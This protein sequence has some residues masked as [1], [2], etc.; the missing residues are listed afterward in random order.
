MA[1]LGEIRKKT[2]LIFVVIGIAMLAFVAGDLFGENSKIK[3]LFT[4]D[5]NQI[6]SINGESIGINE[7]YSAQ[8]SVQNMLQQQGQNVSGNQL[9]Q[10]TWSSLV[11]QKV[12]KQHAE[13]LGLKVS[14]DEFWNYVAQNFGMKSPAEAQQ[15]IAQLEQ[16][17]ASDPNMMQNYKGWL[18]TSEQIKLEILSRKYLSYVMA[19]TAVTG[20]E[21]DLQQTYGGSNATIDYAFVDYKSLAKKLNVTISDDD[22]NAYTSKFPKRFEANGL[23][24]VAYTYFP[25]K[26]SAQDDVVALGNIKK[27]LAQQIRH[28]EVNNVTDTIEA[29]GSTK[30]DSIFVSLNSDQPFISNYFS[31]EDLAKANLTPEIL[32]F[33]KTAQVGQ[34][35]GPYKVGD[36]YQIYKISKSKEVKD[37]VNSNTVYQIA[38]LVKRIE[39]S[40]ATTDAAFKNARTF[41]QNV[42]NKT[43]NDFTAVAKKSNFVSGTS[44]SIERFAPF[45]AQE[46]P[47]DQT[48]KI[49]SWAFDK[50]TAQG[51]TNLFTS[52]NGDYIV[53]HLVNRFDKG[54]AAPSVVREFVEPIL[55]QERISKL[56]D[57]KI[58]TGGIDA[59]IKQF[60]GA[61][62]TTAV[63][64]GNSN[65]Q[66]VGLEPRVVGA[67]FGVKPNTSS[68][69][70]AGNAGVFYITPKS[71]NVPTGQKG[72]ML[73][74]NLNRQLKGQVSQTL[75]PSLIQAADIKDNRDRIIK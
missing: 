59:F 12:L 72:N 66:G 30:N 33:F 3:Q 19:G 38:N 56:V 18:Q 75:L 46:L 61:K 20:K 8:E 11:S 52:E 36:T 25:A 55:L 2:W 51:A 1:V 67:A 28:D 50:K 34:V 49:L 23:V 74:E 69:A 10:Q 15:Q 37:S 60:G 48:D 65:I 57:E 63:N 14:D 26:A 9:A 5:P 29:F 64:F 27:Y 16:A 71:Q 54:L 47:A 41:A 4:G 17:A 42:E 21:A 22:I 45:V 35:G 13:K 7:Y 73:L 62:A 24:K 6:G 53:V 40:K 31:R 68:K 58:G 43:L 32:E 39:P 44:E 70:I